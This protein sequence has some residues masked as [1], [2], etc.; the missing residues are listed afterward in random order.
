MR[1]GDVFTRIYG[2]DPPIGFRAYDGSDVAVDS[3]PI[4]DVR[5]PAALNYLVSA[6]KMEL[7]LARAYITGALDV[8]GDLY[9]A[10]RALWYRQIDIPTREKLRLF[11]N[12]GGVKLLRRPPL[13]HREARL[14]GRK[15]S[16]ARDAAAI[17]HHYDVG[18]DFYALVLGESMTYTCAVY[19][20]ET[21]S[22]E[23]AQFQKYD[24]VAKKL[25][26]EPGMRLL[27][28]GCG[29]GGMVLHAA[30]HYGVTVIGATL[31]RQ[32]AEWGAKAISQAGLEGRAEIRFSDYRDVREGQFDAISSIGLTE[33]VGPSNLA[34][35]FSFLRRKLRVGGRLLNHCIT[36]PHN[37]GPAITRGGFISTY[38]F[39]DG[40][41]SG[42]GTLMSHM[43]DAGFEVRHE[44]NLRE[45]YALT[46]A[47]WVRNLEENWAEAVALV[48]EQTARA[49]RLYLVGSRLGFESDHI[50]LH[51]M[52]GV[53]TAADG[54]ADMPLRPQWN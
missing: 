45:H 26:L 54:T 2:E 47:A 53:R 46:L 36:K 40:G 41:L 34:D 44:E 12:L 15:H 38:V 39:P 13:P 31:S 11:N 25:G 7:G 16:K 19:P 6:R 23:D 9:Q 51:Q 35:Y 18:N 4:L 28:V 37:R 50:Q 43:H 33:H 27:D 20:D 24:L 8:V 22:L 30:K 10:M 1:L 3:G 48:G 32:Q 29:W 21:A 42:P 5:R 14:S 49:W 52:L 17:A